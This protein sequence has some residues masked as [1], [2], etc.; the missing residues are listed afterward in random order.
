M[1]SSATLSSSPFRKSVKL[2]TA[3]GAVQ[4]LEIVGAPFERP[5]VGLCRER[6]IF[7]EFDP[8]AA[9]RGRVGLAAARLHARSAQPFRRSDW[10]VTQLGNAFGIWWWDADWVDEQLLLN[11]IG[12][13]VHLLPETFLRMT[14]EGG[15]VVRTASGYE[16]QF[17]RSDF[18]V[19]DSW[20]RQP[21]TD[22]A[23]FDFIR[24]QSA[25]QIDDKAPP[26]QASP[27]IARSPYRRMLASEL[28]PEILARYAISAFAILVFAATAYL[29]AETISFDQR[30][31]KVEDQTAQI[32]QGG[33]A[34]R[35]A[36]VQV[37]IR[38]LDAI[39]RR[40]ETPDPLSLLEAAQTIV[41]PFGYKINGFVADA[42]HLRFDLP[43]ES[44][45]GIDLIAT[46]LAA[47]PYFTN[48]RTKLN[49]NRKVLE[50]E[51]TVR[52]RR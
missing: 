43:E 39:K 34:L 52:R 4:D 12:G 17:W 32:L 45:V 19:A 44:A 40:V 21:F 33:A 20:R 50:I 22:Q 28:T 18:L 16:A 51:M 37:K 13:Q 6:C 7:G 42:N 46:E 49:R 35:N 27:Y 25:E 9:A 29:L 8:P 11:G 36:R 24:L 3:D 10:L 1:A 26:V 14:G 23:W 2:L 47:S 38:Q 15:R 31:R 48:I 5:I 41:G 30:T